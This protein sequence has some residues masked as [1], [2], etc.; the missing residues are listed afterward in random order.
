MGCSGPI[1]IGGRYILAPGFRIDGVDGGEGLAE[2]CPEDTSGTFKLDFV[3][4]VL[5]VV[6]VVVV[7]LAEVSLTMAVFSL[8]VFSLALLSE[9]ALMSDELLVAFDAN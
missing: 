3:A 8:A 6:V 4:V 7:L 9:L 2:L 1:G 5:L